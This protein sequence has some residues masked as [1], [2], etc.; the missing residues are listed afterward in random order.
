MAP[1][2]QTDDVVHNEG[3]RGD[4]ENFQKKGNAHKSTVYISNRVLSAEV[5][6]VLDET[7]AALAVDTL[8]HGARGPVNASSRDYPGR[9]CL[10]LSYGLGSISGN[11]SF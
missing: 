4:R 9:P 10:T 3:F 11:G 1:I 8:R 7:E 5:L 2:Q 6:R